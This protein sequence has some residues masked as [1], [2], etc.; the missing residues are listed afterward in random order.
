MDRIIIFGDP[1]SQV[2]AIL[3][4]ATL[5]QISKKGDMQ[6]VAVVDAGAQSPKPFYVR[7]AR[8]LI[9]A[10]LIRLFNP[11]QRFLSKRFILKKTKGLL[12]L[13]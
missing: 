1:I 7:A 6:V 8:Y 10:A 13:V 12:S 4:E 5:Q 2:T 11:K 9:R 3:L